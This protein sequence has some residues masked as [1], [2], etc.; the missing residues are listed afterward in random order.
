MRRDLRE[1]GKILPRKGEKTGCKIIMFGSQLYKKKYVLVFFFFFFFF[2]F[3]LFN[4]L[5][6]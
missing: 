3:N 5:K 6:V 4:F 1:M 2:F